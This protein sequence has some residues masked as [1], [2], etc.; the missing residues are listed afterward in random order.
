MLLHATVGIDMMQMPIM[1]VI[2]VTIVLQAGVFAVRPVLVIMI[3][4]Q[5]SHAKNPRLGS[6]QRVQETGETSPSERPPPAV[7]P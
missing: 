3:G 6:K 5:V 2:H 1:Q 4:V 7:R